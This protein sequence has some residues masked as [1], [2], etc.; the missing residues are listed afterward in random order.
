LNKL[1]QLDEAWELFEDQVSKGVLKKDIAPILNANGFTTLKGKPWSY[2]TLMLEQRRRKELSPLGN[3][4]LVSEVVSVSDELSK[5]SV[6]ELIQHF[7]E[8]ESLSEVEVADAL[9][10]RGYLD[11]KGRPWNHQSILYELGNRWMGQEEDLPEFSGSLSDLI[12]KSVSRTERENL[13]KKK[14]PDMNQAWEM[15]KTQLEKGV[16]KKKLMHNL[17]MGGFHT[18]TGKPWTYQTLLLEIKRMELAGYFGRVVDKFVV[19]TP[20]PKVNSKIQAEDSV[21]IILAKARKLIQKR[22]VEVLNEKGARTRSGSPWSYSVLM[23]ELLKLDLDPE[24][25]KLFNSP[26]DVSIAEEVGGSEFFSVN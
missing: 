23:T 1:Q 22:V 25:T 20:A 7:M 6:C 14:G 24:S 3:S 8:S 26:A 10:E 18:R 21:D 15:I 11:R 16:K 2:Q 9:N 4:Q 13:A 5:L 17:N 19:P 12:E